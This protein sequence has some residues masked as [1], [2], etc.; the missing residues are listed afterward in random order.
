M[1][2]QDK[3]K[4]LSVFFPAY[5]EEE[6]IAQTIEKAWNVLQ[7]I[8]IPFEI[9]II[10]DGS[11][12]KTAEVSEK[13]TK[14]YQQMR[15]INQENGGYGKALRTGFSEAKYDW[16]VYTDS[17]GQFDFS[18]VT[19]FLEKTDIA[20]YIIGFRLKRSDPFYRL[21]TA[22]LWALSV[23]LLF[24]IWVK[25]IDCG[26]KMINKKAIQAAMPLT[27]GRGAMINA[28]LLIKVKNAK[29]RIA[30]VGVHHY[31]R[32][33]GTPT[34]VNMKVIIQSYRDLFALRNRLS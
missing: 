17:D 7:S 1:Q 25:D 19:K 34:G 28:E 32:M 2:S 13:L 26:F 11:K 31:P 4:S 8:H 27:S 20:D 3:P 33:L 21:V 12:D 23:F 14:K 22:K 10:N 18:D 29:L 9:L 15:L 16:V 5:N 6:N 30:Q 24:G